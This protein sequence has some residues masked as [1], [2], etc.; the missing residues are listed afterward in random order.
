MSSRAPVGVLAFSEIDVAVNQGYIAIT[1]DKELNKFFI[2]CWL[3]ENID[4]IHAY[5]NGSTFMEISKKSFKSIKCLIPPRSKHDDFIALVS[6]LFEKI[7]LNEKS[8][9]NL[10]LLR[11][12][13][14]PKLI[15]GQVRVKLD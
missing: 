12:T 10:S 4:T 6:P 9:L 5:S 13:L 3:K 8:S 7:K 14:L 11:D 15:S 2:Y 1:D